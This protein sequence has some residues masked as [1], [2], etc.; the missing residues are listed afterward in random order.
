M[1]YYVCRGSLTCGKEAAVRLARQLLAHYWDM[2]RDDSICPPHCR[3]R[4]RRALK[5]IGHCLFE[6]MA[7]RIINMVP[8]GVGMLM[9][10]WKLG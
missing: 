3:G 9:Q 10:L 2:L 4:D 5:L 7:E 1:Y 8:D 6:I